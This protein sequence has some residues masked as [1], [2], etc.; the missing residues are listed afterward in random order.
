MKEDAIKVFG[1]NEKTIKVMNNPLDKI[2]IN[3]S[4]SNSINPFEKD[5]SIY[6]DYVNLVTGFG[7]EWHQYELSNKIRLNPDSNYTYGTTDTSSTYSYKKNRLKT[8]F[9]NVPVSTVIL[10]TS[11]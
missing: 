5:I 11:V 3:Q 8:S 9:I 10:C 2:Y 4:I 1:L 7:F 6:K